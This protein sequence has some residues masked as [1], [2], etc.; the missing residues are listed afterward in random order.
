MEV[1]VEGGAEG[2]NS[3]EGNE[4]ANHRQKQLPLPDTPILC[5]MQVMHILLIMF[6]I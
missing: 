2:E 6:F 3:P 5:N 1:V 4:N